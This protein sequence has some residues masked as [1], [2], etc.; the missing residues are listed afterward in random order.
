MT[1]LSMFVKTASFPPLG[2]TAVTTVAVGMSTT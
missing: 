2:A 1:T